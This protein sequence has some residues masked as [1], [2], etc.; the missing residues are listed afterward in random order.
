MLKRFPWGTWGAYRV[1]SVVPSLKSKQT[2]KKK[3]KQKKTKK[4]KINTHT[5]KQ[6]HKKT[7]E[8]Q[9]KK[10]LP[11]LGQDECG[12]V[13]ARAHCNTGDE[14]AKGRGEGEKETCCAAGHQE[15]SSVCLS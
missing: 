10:I 15:S 1:R 11:L 14:R 12:H 7:N 3:N 9:Q 6:T 5:T 13:C 4:K 8:N 2:N